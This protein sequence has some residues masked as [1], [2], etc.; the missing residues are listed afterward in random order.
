MKVTCRFCHIGCFH[1]NK[2]VAAWGRIR[3]NWIWARIALP[4]LSP[5]Y[6]EL[7]VGMTIHGLSNQRFNLWM[8]MSSKP[9]IP[10]LGAVK[11]SV[12]IQVKTLFWGFFAVC[13]LPSLLTV[14]ASKWQSKHWASASTFVLTIHKDSWQQQLWNGWITIAF[15]NSYVFRLIRTCCLPT[16]LWLLSILGC[17]SVPVDPTVRSAAKAAWNVGVWWWPG[18]GTERWCDLLKLGYLPV[19]KPH[20]KQWDFFRSKHV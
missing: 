20:L 2:M 19:S 7:V 11:T 3:Q 18:G 10:E 17:I 9:T 4:N 5:T 12:Y 16:M 6:L 13:G 8:A 14:L 15:T 1:I